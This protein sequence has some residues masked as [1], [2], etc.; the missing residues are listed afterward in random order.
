[1][2]GGVQC[3]Q[4]PLQF[5][6]RDQGK[7]S[8]RAQVCGSMGAEQEV[9]ISYVESV[10][11]MLVPMSKLRVRGGK[12]HPPL[13]LFLEKSVIDSCPS[14]SSPAH[15]LKGVNTSPSHIH[16]LFQTSASIAVSSQC[17]CVLPRIWTPLSQFSHRAF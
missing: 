13:P 15:N 16:Q 14:G 5:T 12:W 1:M 4:E 8:F 3:Q 9:L 7:P 6:G 11:V 10:E 17:C 2:Q